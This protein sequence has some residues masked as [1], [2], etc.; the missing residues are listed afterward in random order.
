MKSYSQAGQD[1]YVQTMLQGKRNGRYIEIG[2]FD[3]VNISNT[4][5]LENEFSWS[6]FSLDIVPNFVDKFNST[7]VN[8]CFLADG[9]KFDYGGKIK[10]LWGD[11][12][13]IDYPQVNCELVE[14]TFNS[15]CAVPLD[16]YRFSV[17]TFET[18]FYSSGRQYRDL[19]RS[20]LWNH[21]YFLVASNVNNIGGDPFEDWWIDPTVIN[22]DVYE[23]I[24]C[25]GKPG[26]TIC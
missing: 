13:R 20:Y 2:A 8:E 26:K 14:T 11:I 4:F 1:R 23:K 10:E 16:R 22:S 17:I 3:P 18:E 25:S 5:S 12:D 19:S 15:L 21:G 6:G 7:R 24:V 9:T